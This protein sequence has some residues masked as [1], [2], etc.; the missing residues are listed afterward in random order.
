MIDPDVAAV[1]MTV[2]AY[3]NFYF[4][5]PILASKSWGERILLVL[6]MTSSFVHHITATNRGVE[7][8]VKSDYAHELLWTDRLCAALC[9]IYPVYSGRIPSRP[10]VGRMLL[11]LIPLGIS[12]LFCLHLTT[13]AILYCYTFFHTIW[14]LMAAHIS[15]HFCINKF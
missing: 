5:V 1:C 12:D 14:H 11:A 3:S 13:P 2:V 9:I 4:I 6:A 7:P 8:L 10:T 15:L